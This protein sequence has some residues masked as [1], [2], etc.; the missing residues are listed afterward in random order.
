M[1]RTKNF[2]EGKIYWTKNRN[3]EQF[4]VIEI[5]SARLE[6]GGILIEFLDGGFRK[7]YDARRLSRG[8][9]VS[10]YSKTVFGVGFVGEGRFIPTNPDKSPTREYNRWKAMLQRCYDVKSNPKSNSYK[11]CEVAD[12]WLNFQD[13]AEWITKQYG[14]END[15]Q[16]DKDLLKSRNGLY[17][18][19]NCCLIPSEINQAL[20]S[21][22][23][24]SN[25]GLPCGV[26]YHKKNG[27]Y[28]S[29]VHTE[30]TTY[31]GS[32]AT[33]E[34]AWKVAKRTKEGYIKSLAE[35]YKGELDERVYTALN[36]YEYLPEFVEKTLYDS[37]RKGDGYE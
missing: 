17:S 9:I 29:H 12:K 26:G 16:L 18:P 13:F 21:K 32:F 27:V 36:N 8:Q 22:P 30:D 25:N 15:W 7:W 3:P 10:P 1:K 37:A 31:Q 19:E 33:A 28:V 11:V 6:N 24:N 35:K 2:E 34:Q 20:L 23:S 5:V 14:W 4:K